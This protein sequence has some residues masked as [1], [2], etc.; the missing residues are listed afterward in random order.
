MPKTSYRVP[1][2]LDRSYL[3]QEIPITGGGWTLPPMPIKAL[4][5]YM[6]GVVVML[7]MSVNS[8][9]ADGPVWYRLGFLVWCLVAMVVLGRVSKTKEL[10]TSLIMPLL[11]YIPAGARKV[12][13]RSNSKASP[14]YSIV[15]VNEIGKEDKEDGIIQFA[16]GRFARA[17][18]VVGSA[19]VLLFEDDKRAILDRVDAFW[20]KVMPDTEFLFITTKEPQRIYRQVASLERT[21]RNLVVRDPE[22]LDLLD[23]QYD[24]MTGYVGKQFRSIHQYLVIMTK[25]REQLRQAHNVIAAEVEGSSFMIKAANELSGD[26]VVEMLSVLYQGRV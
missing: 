22:L 6:A 11:Y 9:V 26:E 1:T 21:N 19:S 24:I 8:F 15:G 16:D 3:D 25:T 13:T 5:F 2:S 14:F 12:L 23:E 20:R 17:Y 7:W 10:K 4:L 18:L